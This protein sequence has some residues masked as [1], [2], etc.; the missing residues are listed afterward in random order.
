MTNKGNQP[1]TRQQA[2]RHDEGTHSKSVKPAEMTSAIGSPFRSSNA[3]V[4]TV[5]PMRM[6]SIRDVSIG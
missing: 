5:V 4:A 1:H 2:H 3:F 6:D